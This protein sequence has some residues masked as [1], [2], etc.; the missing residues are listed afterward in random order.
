MRGLFSIFFLSIIS[1]SASCQQFSIDKNINIDGSKKILFSKGEFNLVLITSSSDSIQKLIFKSSQ[2]KLQNLD[3]GIVNGMFYLSDLE[4]GKVTISV[5]KQIDTVL[6][7]KNYKVYNVIKK[8]LTPDEIKINKLEIKPIFSLQGYESGKVPLD[9]AKSATKFTINKP[10]KLKSLVAYF[11]SNK[12]FSNPIIATLNS[13]IFDDNFLRIWKRISIG[14]LIN[15]ENVEIIDNKG[16]IYKLN[17]KGFIIV[18]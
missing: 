7:L 17:L 14:T 6:Q 2:G 5:F 11:G 10:Y 1:L 12:G 9:I 8:P 13:E 4:V 18:E 3:S 15:L 16:I